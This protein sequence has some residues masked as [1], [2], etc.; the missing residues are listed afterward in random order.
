MHHRHSHLAPIESHNANNELNR[1]S[2]SSSKR[3]HSSSAKP[4]TRFPLALAS[5]SQLAA[6][7]QLADIFTNFT[8]ANTQQEGTAAPIIR[9]PPGFETLTA[10]M[11]PPPRVDP[12]APTQAHVT[13]ADPL[14]RV[15]AGLATDQDEASLPRVETPPKSKEP[16]PSALKANPW[17]IAVASNREET[18]ANADKNAGQRR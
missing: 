7:R 6:L 16:L 17:F 10:P 9:A 1:S 12:V 8:H 11:A 4:N 15:E 13:F 2:D 3:P 14:P 5:D 18:Y